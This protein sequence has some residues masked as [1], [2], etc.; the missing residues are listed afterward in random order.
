MMSMQAFFASLLFC[1]CSLENL[2]NTKRFFGPYVT[3]PLNEAKQ[4]V[5]NYKLQ[6]RERTLS[7]LNELSGPFNCFWVSP[8]DSQKPFVQSQ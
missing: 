1:H 7:A 4:S 2:E 8:L 6:L 3:F 5:L